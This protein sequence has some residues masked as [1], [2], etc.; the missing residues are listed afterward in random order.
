MA[1][2]FK[3]K[4][5]YEYTSVH[6]DDLSFGIGQIITVTDQEGDDWYEGEYVDDDGAK[7]EG[8]FPSNFVEKFEPVAPPRPARSR[9]KK[10]LEKEPEKE[11]EAARH[12]SET[13]AQPSIAAV[14]HEEPAP[15]RQTKPGPEHEEAEE[16]M[17][18]TSLEK[19]PPP[20]AEPANIAESIPVGSPPQAAPKATAPAP[21]PAASGPTP[22]A[23]PPPPEK[24][25]SGT[26]KDRIAAFNKP[27]AAPIAPFKPGAASAGYSKKPFVPP[28]PSRDAYVPV[29]KD[30]PMPPMGTYKR[31][32]DPEIKDRE[33]EN[34][35]HA[36]KAGLVPAVEGGSQG[37]GEE[38]QP[39]PT[40]LRERIALLQKQQ[41]EQAQRHADAAAKKEKPK[42]PPVKKRIESSSQPE[43]MGDLEETEAPP[44][45]ERRDTEDLGSRTST[46]EGPM[47]QTPPPPRRKSSKGPAIP[48]VQDG[49]EA[50]MSGAGDT[51]EGQDDPTEREEMESMPIQVSRAPTSSIAGTKDEDV[52]DD[53]E[54]EEEEEEEDDDDP[55]AKRK[56]ELRARMA[57][58]SGGMGFHGMFGA[59]V[60]S[61]GPPPPKKKK[62]PRPEALVEEEDEEAKPAAVAPQ[63]IPAMMALPAR[64]PRKSEEVGRPDVEPEPVSRAVP[65]PVPSRAIE[66]EDDEDDDE[67]EEEEDAATP[68][69]ATGPHGTARTQSYTVM[70]MPC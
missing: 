69:P 66:E 47:G 41:V 35:E 44:P 50:D 62:A 55:E 51:T 45:P 53:D 20:V 4:A 24:P 15:I 13:S 2:A 52:A 63:P 27:S 48:T 67:E 9:T 46:D 34:L 59:P 60:P 64:G 22:K 1:A 56:E 5:L 6:E 10:D 23:K 57:K 31:E 11:T 61:A 7:H 28:P 43:V 29:P 37:D 70:R 58:M 38:E 36:Q 3:V 17:T 33:A 12:A 49:N 21:Q 30:K 8:L 25:V 40:S 16:P 26:F 54:E 39:K 14:T 19:S 42:K 65:P 68:A 18:R 32:E